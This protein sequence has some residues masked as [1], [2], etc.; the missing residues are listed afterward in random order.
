MT[1]KTNLTPATQLRAAAKY[2]KANVKRFGLEFA[3]A[4][5][6]LLEHIRTQPNMQGYVKGLIRADVERGGENAA[7]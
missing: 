6:D 7:D 2:K 3:P 5:W 1:G 4:D